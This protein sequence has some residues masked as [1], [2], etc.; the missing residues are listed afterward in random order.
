[1]AAGTIQRMIE[2]CRSA[3]RALNA[4]ISLVEL[5]A[6]AM[7]IHKAMTLGA[8]S[9]H[10]PEHIFDLTDGSNPIQALAALF[11]DVVY[12]QVDE[13]F[14]PEIYLT[15]APYIQR[16]EH[17]LL[18]A[19]QQRADDVGLQLALGVFGF[20]VGQV[21]PTDGQNEF[22]SAL[23]MNKQLEDL[24]S[25][26]NLLKATACIEA[27]IPFR[28]K[29]AQ[30]RRPAE[31]L[32]HRLSQ[33]NARRELGLSAEEI[34]QAVKWAV[35]FSNKDVSNF[36]EEDPGRFLDNTWK[37]L[38]ETNPSLR[39]RGIYSIWSYRQA[40]YKMRTF[41]AD[42]KPEHIFNS[43]EGTPPE[44]QY[45]Y[46]VTMAHRNLGIA[47]RYLDVKLLAA[48]ILVALAEI[49]GGDAPVALFMGDLDGVSDSTAKMEDFLP[50][51]PALPSVDTESTVYRLLAYGR[52][53]ATE[54]DL[55]HSPLALFIYRRLEPASM[56]RLLDAAN[57]MFEG[58]L[59][60]AAFLDLMPADLIAT[61]AEAAAQL[62]TTRQSA[63]TA[64][65]AA[66]RQ[67]S[68]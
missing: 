19:S 66:R 22:L 46:M 33:V 14:A 57:L 35:D 53:S 59:A 45:R 37:L 49:S 21:L 9:F 5:E 4:E 63:L 61:I 56:H 43:Y 32:A 12:Y 64:F 26:Q 3:L 23:V 68:E 62:A 48:S 36:A 16:R 18:I 2:L 8:R 50:D 60:P 28:G 27:T 30:G 13:G 38:P 39:L 47:R 31:V 41:L 54:F 10:T 52:A 34:Q 25:E 29:D 20:R 6:L 11:H 65:A 51:W 7:R 24:V 1:M 15:L 17:Q 67:A 40:L 58:A 55:K 42:L 44:P